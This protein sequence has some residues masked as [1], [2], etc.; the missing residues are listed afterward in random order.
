MLSVVEI[1]N[2]IAKG[3]RK[4][5]NGVTVHTL[6]FS[7][8]F[9]V[10]TSWKTSTRAPL[11]DESKESIASAP[12]ES[13]EFAFGCFF[14]SVSDDKSLLSS[15]SCKH[16][17]QHLGISKEQRA[18]KE[19]TTRSLNLDPHLISCVVFA[20]CSY[21]RFR[22]SFILFLRRTFGH[23]KSD[24]VHLKLNLVWPCAIKIDY[25]WERRVWIVCMWNEVLK[26]HFAWLSTLG[27][28]FSALGKIGF[29]AF[30]QK[31]QKISVAQLRLSCFLGDPILCCRSRIYVALSLIQQRNFRLAKKILRR[32]FV[33]VRTEFVASEAER[34][35]SIL[36]SVWLYLLSE[37]ED[38]KTEEEQRL[39]QI[40]SDKLEFH[41]ETI[42][43]KKSLV[44]TIFTISAVP[45]PSI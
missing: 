3:L 17:I 33:F 44:D 19:G 40:R 6:Y 39:L 23:K 18:I 32:E 1:V 21:K 22:R 14:P 2:P 25:A 7:P 11:V 10:V 43:S 36:Q 30:A 9:C 12:L 28:A 38:H 29:R 4:D 26:E 42:R 45:A 8:D 27:G 31:A 5:S 37:K 16:K 41:E 24:V 13:S 15:S 20:L 34:L 35:E